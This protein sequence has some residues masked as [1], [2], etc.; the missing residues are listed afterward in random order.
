VPLTLPLPTSIISRFMLH[1]C[2]PTPTNAILSAQMLNVGTGRIVWYGECEQHHHSVCAAL[3]SSFVGRG[4]YP[5]SAPFSTLTGQQAD[6]L[7]RV[8]RSPVGTNNDD[9]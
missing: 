1:P 7:V 3:S 6:G 4:K 9:A 5:R 8:E 2:R